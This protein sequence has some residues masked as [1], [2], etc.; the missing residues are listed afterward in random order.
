MTDK[1]RILL[2][3]QL[4]KE[5]LDIIKKQALIIEAAGIKYP[6]IYQSLG[7]IS[8]IYQQSKGLDVNEDE[9]TIQIPVI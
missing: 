5:Y 2:L 1:R 9:I 6:T 3:R 7:H 8:Q 4:N